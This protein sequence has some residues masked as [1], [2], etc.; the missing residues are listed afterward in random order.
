MASR[1]L[2]FEKAR[3]FTATRTLTPL[4]PGCLYDICV[5]MP[6]V[7]PP[8]KTILKII[9]PKIFSVYNIQIWKKNLVIQNL[10][11]KS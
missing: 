7:V 1:L 4:T 11:F 3:I 10:K 6:E 9:N 2:A 5:H 8:L